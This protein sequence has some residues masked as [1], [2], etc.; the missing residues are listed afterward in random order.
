M[1]TESG[2]LLPQRATPRLVIHAAFFE[3][4]GV[5]G[6]MECLIFS[7]SLNLMQGQKL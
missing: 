1:G 3:G 4:R 2:I 5:S 7:R 6:L